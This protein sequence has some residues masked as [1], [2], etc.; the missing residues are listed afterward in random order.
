L[1]RQAREWIWQQQSLEAEIYWLIGPACANM[2][3]RYERIGWP[4]IDVDQP[5]GTRLGQHVR[6]D[7]AGSRR[8]TFI[9]LN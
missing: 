7:C 9:N 2:Q 4:S 3:A 5:A 1:C 8:T 6:Q